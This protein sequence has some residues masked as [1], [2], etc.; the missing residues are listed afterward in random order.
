MADVHDDV[1]GNAI[2]MER[3]EDAGVPE[4]AS[5]LSDSD[6]EDTTEIDAF[7]DVI[8]LDVDVDIAAWDEDVD[9]SDEG[10]DALDGDVVDDDTDASDGDEDVLAEGVNNIDHSDVPS[11]ANSDSNGESELETHFSPTQSQ[12]PDHGGSTNI[13]TSGANEDDPLPHERAYMRKQKFNQLARDLVEEIMEL[14]PSPRLKRILYMILQL[15]LKHQRSNRNRINPKDRAAYPSDFRDVERMLRTAP[16]P[17][18]HLWTT[19]K[20]EAKYVDSSHRKRRKLNTSPTLVDG[21]KVDREPLRKYDHNGR[22][23]RKNDKPRLSPESLPQP[24][25]MEHHVKTKVSEEDF[26]RWAGGP[27]TDIPDILYRAWDEYSLCQIHDPRVGFLSGCSECHLGTSESRCCELSTHADWGSRHRGPFISFTSCWQE[28]WDHRVYALE[29]RQKKHKGKLVNI[30]IT[31]VNA[32]ARCAARMP[33]L[34]MKHELNHYNV[35][36]P[37]GNIRNTK[38]SFFENEY[39]LPFVI[40]PSEI[41]LTIPWHEIQD[42]AEKNGRTVNDWGKEVGATL[43]E[44]HEQDRLAGTTSSQQACKCCGHGSGCSCCGHNPPASSPE[45]S[46]V[47]SEQVHMSDDTCAENTPSTETERRRV[48]HE[49]SSTTPT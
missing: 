30:K 7:P 48:F 12:Q 8:T 41:I 44:K 36:T 28:I 24:A 42:W 45:T 26:R 34:R 40:S 37:Y 17:D 6:I 32:R 18:E 9:V 1:M 33:I 27:R 2:S 10:L 43:F 46:G 4:Y 35:K 5:T 21:E 13:A 15:R 31:I 39:L 49:H 19:D 38:N 11:G 25:I 29:K 16:P 47:R 14:E 20:R 3:S 23:W 22:S